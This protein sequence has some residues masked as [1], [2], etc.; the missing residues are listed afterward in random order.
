MKRLFFVSLLVTLFF[1]AVNVSAMTEAELRKKFDETVTINGKK[2]SISD[3]DKKLA[4]D[5]FAKYEISSDDCD[6]IA[7]QIDK[8][9]EILT[10]EGKEDLTKLSQSTKDKLKKLVAN[11]SANTSVKGTV[12]SGSVIVLNEDGTTFAEVTHLVKQTGSEVSNVAIIAGISFIITLVGAC[13]VVK[14][15]KN[16]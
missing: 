8:A 6:Y 12:T 15:V 9:K 11:V 1:G 13:L 2:Y 3:G 16:N 14:Q 10:A 4:D 7:K 5:Y